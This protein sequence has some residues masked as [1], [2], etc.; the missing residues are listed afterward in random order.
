MCLAGAV[1]YC[2]AVVLAQFTDAHS[3]DNAPIGINQI[4]LSYTYARANTSIDNSLIIA[5]AQLNLNQGA[6]DYTRY[7][8]F[9]RHTAWVEAGVPIAGLSGSISGT[10]IQGSTTGVGDSSYEFATLL[11]GGP[12][13]H[14]AEFQSYTPRTTVGLSLTATA[15]TGFYDST[16]VLNLGSD[17][18]SFKPEL[19]LSHP[20]AQ[21][22]QADL[23][24]NAYFYTDNTSYHGKELLRQQPLPGF[25][26]HI[27]YSFNDRV[28]WSV[29]TRYSFR[30]TTFVDGMDQDNAQQNF[31]LGSELNVSINGRNSMLFEFA[32]ALVHNNG[33]AVAG[34]SVKYY[35]TWGKGYH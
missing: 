13:L 32:K 15:R 1:V 22:W 9:F 4:E 31:A 24:A 19:A 30:G 33:P 35:Y 29:D 23:Y 10:N 25:E 34:F 26:G 3:Y 12:A 5:G 8:G 14:P 18:W 27:S 6:V 2:P 7:F 11:V 17:R 20:F 21:K 28:W 16:K